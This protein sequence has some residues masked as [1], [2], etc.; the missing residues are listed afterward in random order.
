M[1]S[2]KRNRRHML[3]HE[4]VSTLF[5][6]DSRNSM[7]FDSTLKITWAKT[8]SDT[9]VTVNDAYV[10]RMKSLKIFHF[11]QLRLR[12]LIQILPLMVTQILI[13]PKFNYLQEI[14]IN[15]EEAEQRNLS[16]ETTQEAM[17]KS[18]L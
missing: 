6:K 8:K 5:N 1:V 3:P 2:G 16:V 11:I 9:R 14:D 15:Q 13:L 17:R 7:P 18:F 4:V 10:S 12:D